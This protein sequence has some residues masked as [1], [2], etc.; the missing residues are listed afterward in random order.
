[1]G[2]SLFYCFDRSNFSPILKL[3]F[4]KQL[5]AL[6]SLRQFWDYVELINKIVDPQR[7]LLKCQLWVF[8]WMGREGVA[9]L[10]FGVGLPCFENET[11]I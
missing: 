7:N 6:Y 5:N 9:S 3:L 10:N 1:M 11:S 8:G 4:N 2:W